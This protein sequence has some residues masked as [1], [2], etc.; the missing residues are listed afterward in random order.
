MLNFAYRFASCVSPQGSS[1]NR[2]RTS[3]GLAASAFIPHSAMKG[4]ARKHDGLS[5]LPPMRRAALTRE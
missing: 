3:S 4:K 1:R 2:L 5:G